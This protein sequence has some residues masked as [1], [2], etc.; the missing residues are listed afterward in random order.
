V[1][2]RRRHRG[3]HPRDPDLFGA[4]QLPALRAA[5][6]EL[7]WLLSR[8]YAEV[9]AVALVGD[10]HALAARQRLAVRRAACSDDALAARA[11]RRVDPSALG[12]RALA[13]D[14]FNC[15]IIV[16]SALSGGLLVRGRD[17]CVRDLASVHGSYRTVDE[18]RAAVAALG[19]AIGD[20]AGDVKWYLDRPVSNSGRLAALLRAT[21]AAAGRPWQVTL[22]DA[23]D[24]A[25][26]AS[27]AIVATADSW[28]LDRC[29]PWIDLPAA[30]IG[31]AAAD[32]WLIDLA[33]R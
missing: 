2:D 6:A 13:V 7:S 12:G 21:A 30:A 8:G 23:P 32:A 24:P 16:E 1:P 29:G 26:A 33:P 4:P 3:A 11:R 14:G 31:A 27:P 15:I 18:T 20:A 25:L 10:R 5:V 17:G 22:L 28:I 19:G 9:A